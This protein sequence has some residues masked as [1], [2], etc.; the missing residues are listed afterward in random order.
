M[1]DLKRFAQELRF[2]EIGDP[3]RRHHAAALRIDVDQAKTGQPGERLPDWR[4]AHAKG[5]RHRL[6]R[7]QLVRL[8]AEG[9]DLVEQNLE[10][11]GRD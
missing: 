5:F 7:N 10:R 9:Q 4:A 6:F 8:Q 3:E 11:P 1:A 2:L